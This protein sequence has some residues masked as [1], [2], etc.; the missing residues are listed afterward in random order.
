M[1][2]IDGPEPLD[3]DQLTLGIFFEL[4][5][6]REPALSVD[7]AFD[8]DVILSFRELVDPGRHIFI[9]N[10]FSSHLLVLLVHWL[11]Q[12]LGH[13]REIIKCDL[14]GV[15]HEGEHIRTLVELI[16]LAA[17]LYTWELGFEF[18]QLGSIK[19]IW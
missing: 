9:S 7:I 5:P 12:F 14:R 3:V 11:Q 6:H 19:D 16:S 18:Q 17:D 13:V 1:V 2:I 4:V 8:V 15:L 10:G